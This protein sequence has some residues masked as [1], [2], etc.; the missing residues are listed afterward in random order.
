MATRFLIGKAELLT[1]EIP[2]PAIKPNKVHPYSLSEAKAHLVPQIVA[3]ALEIQTLPPE[4][5]PSDIAVAKIDLH[6]AYIAKSFFPTGLLREAGLA[7]IGSRTVRVLPRRELRKT[8]GP[9]SESTQ[10]FVAGRR[11]AF[12]RLPSLATQLIDRTTE[13]VQFAEIETFSSMRSADRVRS[14]EG[15]QGRAYEV[16]LHLFPDQSV[17]ALRKAFRTYAHRCDFTVNAEFDFPVGRMLFVAVFGPALQLDRLAQFSL[18]R[19]VRPMPTIR[20]ARP[21][22]RGNPIAVN[23]KLPASA[24]LSDE[25]KVA[26]LDGGLPETH[27]L[28]P[29]VG[30]YEK[31]DATAGDVPDYL[32][33]GLGVTSAFLF[34]PIE[35]SAEAL[36]P[37]SYVDH[38]R[39]LDDQAEHEDELEL[40]RTL[41]HIEEV[42]LSGT[43]QFLNLSLGPN[44]ATDDD[45]VHS[46]T[47]LL[48]TMLSDG[49]TLMT[50][51]VGNNGK[52]N[53]SMGLNRIQVPADSVNALSVGAANLTG[54]SW[55]RA[56]YSAVGPGRS[57]G[58]RKPDVVAFGGCPKEYFHVPV[59]G[60]SPE[61][62][63]TMGTSFAAPYVLRTAV[64][65]RA[66]LG[67]SVDPLTIRAL[68]VHASQLDPS[69]HV[70]ETG[71]GRVPSDL[72]RVIMCD[73]GVARIIY[74]GSLRPGKYL[75]APVP[76]PKG[77]LTGRVRLSATFCYA[78]PVDVEDAAAYTKA[79][80]TITFRPNATK[81]AGKQAKTRSFFSAREFRTEQEQ[82][83]DLGK[84]ETV[85]HASHRMLGSNLDD[86]VFD[87]HYNARDGGGLAP[88]GADVIRYALVV[89]VEA[90]KHTSLYEDILAAN[91][92][93][94]AIEPRVTLPLRSG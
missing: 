31:S 63:A 86:A 48:D 53:A 28:A 90:P 50:V 33:H 5:C 18:M 75:R 38:F 74:Q 55:S 79:G 60:R 72:N 6:P 49:N 11:D 82:R 21:L 87:I 85:L 69:E 43:Y 40:Y 1:F 88:A 41:A 58:R 24:P 71:W 70:D 20:A 56:D 7:S 54:T 80:L 44:L 57:P 35:P 19:V 78:S 46:W 32:S 59:A 2:P 37:Y 15:Y 13:A 16:G 51:A 76:L 61:L 17:D 22:M 84:W 92:L 3:A 34:G 52:S 29:F 93:L 47:A 89:T 30:R 81:S 77:A 68:L 67:D 94:K 14:T 23:F 25:P 9:E 62:A 42:L 26:I 64:G 8:A 91:R 83:Q 66:V 4:A 73:D 10:L 36:R 27:V 12:A 45:D 65:V 39:V